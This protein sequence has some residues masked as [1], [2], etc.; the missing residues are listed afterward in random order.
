[1]NAYLPR[2]ACAMEAT[3][4]MIAGTLVAGFA[5]TRLHQP[6]WLERPLGS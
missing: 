1:M 6:R 4:A 5:I 2:D 3:A